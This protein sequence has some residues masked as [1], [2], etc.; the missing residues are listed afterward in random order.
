MEDER[1]MGK[2]FH[3]PKKHFYLFVSIFVHFLC[4]EPFGFACASEPRPDA[5]KLAR[6]L[7]DSDSRRIF[8]GR[9]PD[10][11]AS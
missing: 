2:D 8:I 5:P 6:R 4:H 3:R 1:P 9:D 10:A 7:A 11:W